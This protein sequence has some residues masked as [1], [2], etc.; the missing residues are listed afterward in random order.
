MQKTFHFLIVLLVLFSCRQSQKPIDKDRNVTFKILLSPSFDEKAEV[1]LSKTD[2][3]QKIRF[4]IMDRHIQNL[5][6]DTF[7]LKTILLSKNQ[8]TSFDSLIIQKT[9]MTQPRQWTG[10]CDGMPVSFTLIQDLDTSRLFFRSPDINKP[11]SSG[12]NIT[13]ATIDHLKGLYNDSVITDYLHDIES[14]MDQ[15]KRH[16]QKGEHRAIN[17]LREIEYSR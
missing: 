1:I 5:P 6:L 9:K 14:Y 16:I 4:L 12:Y 2:I 11:D 7:Y 17:R 8:Y 13:K 10:C 15:S 3:E